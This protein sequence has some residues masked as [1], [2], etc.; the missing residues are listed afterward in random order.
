VR[1]FSLR[2][3]SP[4]DLIYKSDGS[5]YFTDPFFVLPKLEQDR[6]REQ[7][8]ARIYRVA[9]GDVQ[10]LSTELKGP[11]GIAFSPDERVLYVAK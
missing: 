7:P 6:R 10:L 2:P 3:N 9:K 1:G 8:H 5:L 11:N 4:N